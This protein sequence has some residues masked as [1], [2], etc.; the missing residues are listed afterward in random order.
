MDYS[1]NFALHSS[2]DFGSTPVAWHEDVK[3]LEFG[4]APY[5]FYEWVDGHFGDSED[6][7]APRVQFLDAFY[8][9]L[10][11]RID[12][13]GMATEPRFTLEVQGIKFDIEIF[14]D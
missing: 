8:N 14:K 13:L 7:T 3:I 11:Q 5:S 6:D 4:D 12:E 1:I 10:H 9:A 2:T